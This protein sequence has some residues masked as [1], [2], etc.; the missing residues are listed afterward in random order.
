MF[1]DVMKFTLLTLPAEVAE[2]ATHARP[3]LRRGPRG[4][5]RAPRSPHPP[6][7]RQ[8]PPSAPALLSV[9]GASRSELSSRQQT[10]LSKL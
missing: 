10:Y 9:V 1:W 7:P 6:A 3:P 8:P 4:G 2:A 5:R